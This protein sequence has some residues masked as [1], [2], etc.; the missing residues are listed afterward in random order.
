MAS[1][2][3]LQDTGCCLTARFTPTEPHWEDLFVLAA[4][5]NLA[6]DGKK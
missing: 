2:E 4:S 6:F 3:G 5:Y 1:H